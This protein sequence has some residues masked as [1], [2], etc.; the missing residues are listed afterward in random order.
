MQGNIAH[1]RQEYSRR[2]LS[3]KHIQV[4][5][6]KQ[7][8]LWF[9]EALEC[10]IVEPNIMSLA[11]VNAE[12]KP[13]CRIVLLKGYDERGFVFFTNYTSHKGN[14]LEQNEN[15]ALTFLWLDLERQ[16]RIEGKASKISD[17]ESDAY[18]KSRPVGSRIGAWTSP[19]S[20]PINKEELIEREQ[21]FAKTYDGSDIPRPP[22]WGGYVVK[23]ELI[24]FWQGR[25]NR[26]HDRIQYTKDG[27]SWHIERLGP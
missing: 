15:A 12:A 3:E 27:T 26:L 1:L 9:K 8:D 7:F 18:F 23:P 6:L 19:Q 20:Q 10:K 11:T 5:P 4:D 2:E 21:E 24:E 17:A 25:P 22:F 14:D 16:V 13:S